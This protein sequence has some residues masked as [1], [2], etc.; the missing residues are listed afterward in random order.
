MVSIRNHWQTWLGRPAD[1][2]N[3]QSRINDK[4][5]MLDFRQS[6]LNSTLNQVLKRLPYPL[7]VMLACMRW[8]VAYG[9]RTTHTPRLDSLALI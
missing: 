1:S 8:Y 6:L 5:T 4:P 3:G 9:V 7:A 2:A